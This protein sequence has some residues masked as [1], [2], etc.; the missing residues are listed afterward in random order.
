VSRKQ[1][2]I[3]F[4][5]PVDKNGFLERPKSDSAVDGDQH[6]GQYRREAEHAMR[7]ERKH[8]RLLA[9]RRKPLVQSLKQAKQSGDES[10][11]AAAQRQLDDFDAQHPLLIAKTHGA[12][13]KRVS[14]K[15]MKEL[16]IYMEM[17]HGG[18]LKHVAQRFDLLEVQIRN[19]VRDLLLS[20]ALMHEPVDG[21]KILD[22]NTQQTKTVRGG[23]V[24]HD[25]IGMHNAI[26]CPD[27]RAR[28]IDFGESVEFYFNS[29]RGCWTRREDEAGIAQVPR[30]L[31][32]I[33]P[34]RGEREII[35]PK[36]DIWCLGL[37]LLELVT[38]Q[39]PFRGALQIKD[40]VYQPGFNPLSHPF[41]KLHDED[42]KRFVA[43]PEHTQVA[44]LGGQMLDCFGNVSK[45]CRD[46]IRRCVAPH[47]AD[48]W[49]AKQ[50]LQHEWI[51]KCGSAAS[52]LL[53]EW[54]RADAEAEALRTALFFANGST[55]KLCDSF[56]C[57]AHGQSSPTHGYDM[58]SVSLLQLAPSR[59]P[60]GIP[61]QSG[62]GGSIFHQ[63][64]ESPQRVLSVSI[65]SAACSSGSGS[66]ATPPL[67]PQAQAQARSHA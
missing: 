56:I 7:I 2:A 19:I 34:E 27:G 40:I 25:D 33:A 16:V 41:M 37:V 13:F 9:A 51:R 18:S 10:R 52:P 24:V 5:H 30:N 54:I 20:L 55:S 38:K 31:P 53:P 8:K 1:C 62:L 32:L 48:R 66:P 26:L 28:L 42:Q 29:E 67:Q 58:R 43:D 17:L 15:N 45:E 23:V 36:G 50:L 63:F 11:I 65:T 12:Y 57:A 64:P 14:G 44:D 21:V 39:Q 47:R 61:V 59:H 22:V 60:S 4:V 49:T 35:S 6:V 3:K 46:F